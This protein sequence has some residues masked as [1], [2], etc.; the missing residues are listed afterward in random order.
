M[1]YATTIKQTM[2]AGMDVEIIHPDV[3]V[4]DR[5]ITIS[6]LV[7]NNGWEDKQDVT[8]TFIPSNAIIPVE[9]NSIKIEKIA[10]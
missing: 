1:A 3:A 5:T 6:F 8:F 7:K 10:A 2:E 4:I 9:K